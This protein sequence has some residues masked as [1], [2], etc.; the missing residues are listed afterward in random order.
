[1]KKRGQIWVETVV[2]TLI[3]FALIGIVLA[4]VKPQIEKIQDKAVIDQS[5]EI[6]EQMNSIIT[7]LGGPGNQRVIEMGISKG[8]LTIDAEND[9]LVF[10]I[11]SKYEYSQ[12]GQNVSVGNL[13]AHNEQRG[14]LNEVSLTLNYSGVYNMTY[15]GVDQKRQM[16]AS[17]TPYKITLSNMGDDPSGNTLINMGVLG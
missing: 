15:E 16:S 11:E 5:A 10:E 9:N 8:A 4:F 7:S 13:I 17:A 3:A 14:K 1:M 6:L 2:Y 12:P